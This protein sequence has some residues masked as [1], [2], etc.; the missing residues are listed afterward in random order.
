MAKHILYVMLTSFPNFFI[1]IIH[2]EEIQGF[3][4]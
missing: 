2:I 3:S 4:I 1:S